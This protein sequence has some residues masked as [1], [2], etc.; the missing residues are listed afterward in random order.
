MPFLISFVCVLC[1]IPMLNFPWTL[2]DLL[3]VA[4]KIYVIYLIPRK[5]CRDIY[6]SFSPAPTA[7]TF[8]GYTHIFLGRHLAAA[9][10][11]SNLQALGKVV[12][13]PPLHGYL[14]LTS[15]LGL[16]ATSVNQ[17]PESISLALQ[18]VTRFALV[19]WVVGS[20]LW[21]LGDRWMGRADGKIP[22]LLYPTQWRQLYSIGMYIFGQTKPLGWAL[23]NLVVGALEPPR[24]YERMAGDE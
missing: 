15:L 13:S 18:I 9:P 20:P 21:I 12:Q 14:L 10:L 24:R 7:L 8:S 19:G 3:L 23:V 4:F 5:Y 11:S 22:D 6:L 1:M 17:S 2:S 16:A